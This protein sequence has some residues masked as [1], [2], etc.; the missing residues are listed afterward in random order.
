MMLEAEAGWAVKDR[1]NHSEGNGKLLKSFM[2]NLIY[3]L[4]KCL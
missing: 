3:I 1:V 2:H 4:G